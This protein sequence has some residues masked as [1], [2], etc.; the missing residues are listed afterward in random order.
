LILWGA[1]VLGIVSF[2]LVDLDALI[3][4]LPLPAGTE[5]PTFTPLL[6]ILSLIQPTVIV[7]IATLIGVTLAPK[8]GLSSP[9]AASARYLGH[10]ASAWSPPLQR[11]EIEDPDIDTLILENGAGEWLAFAQLRANQVS[12]GVPAQGSIELWRFYVDAPWQGRGV[13]GALM[14]A[15]KDR[16]RRRGASTMW[17]G[18]WE[19]NARAQAFYRKHGFGRVG[20][21]VFV[22]GG[23]PQTDDVM[24]C[25]LA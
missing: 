19:R 25:A 3:A 9:V 18:V 17:L 21:K 6:K 24:L 1:G 23:D 12:D 14:Q 5:V 7:A 11:R 8:V 20:R 10:L 15:A 2:L 22:V 13:A 16:G 4:S